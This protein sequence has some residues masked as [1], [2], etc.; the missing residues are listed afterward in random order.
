MGVKDRIEDAGVLW[1][2]GRREG[3]WVMALI[4][5]A[6][7][8]RK[9]YPKPETRLDS[10]AFKKFIRDIMPTLTLDKSLHDTQPN[11]GVMFRDKPLEDIIYHH[12]R[13]NLVHEAGLDPAV[14]FSES[15]IVDGE[16]MATLSV[17]S[18]NIIPDF[19]VRNL[20]QAVKGAPENASDFGR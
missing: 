4:A 3:A 8:S 7:T 6:A 14:A 17:G 9:R 13:C 12:L 20:I 16:R 18:P 1:E 2:A 11:P 19:W 10:D 15:K 5:A